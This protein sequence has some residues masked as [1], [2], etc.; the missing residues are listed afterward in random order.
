M[1]LTEQLECLIVEIESTEPTR[2]ALNDFLNFL[3]DWF[4]TPDEFQE[5]RKGARKDLIDNAYQIPSKGDPVQP[6]LK[7]YP[8][9]KNGDWSKAILILRE[10]AQIQKLKAVPKPTNISEEHRWDVWAEVAEFDAIKD[11]NGNPIPKDWQDWTPPQPK[12]PVTPKH[13]RNHNE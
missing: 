10:W 2:A 3:K 1:N 6:Q 13:G 11:L 5:F 4:A 7:F 12:E 8:T 9:W